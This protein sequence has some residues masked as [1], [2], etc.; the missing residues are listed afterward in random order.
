MWYFCHAFKRGVDR[1]Y[2]Y[3][4]PR[5][6]FICNAPWVRAGDVLFG[7]G[8]KNTF[9]PTTPRTP[10]STQCF[11]K[12]CIIELNYKSYPLAWLSLTRDWI[13]FIW[14]LAHVQ[15]ASID[16]TA[17]KLGMASVYA[18]ERKLCDC[19][20]KWHCAIYCRF[21]LLLCPWHS[22]VFLLDYFVSS[23]SSL[24]GSFL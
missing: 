1:S 3:W 16:L 15:M 6:Y 2:T 24:T 8:H 9:R 4:T 5:D 7:Q 10:A 12:V 22:D 13:H 20:I 18:T 11:T 23:H 14:V 17:V 21:L 19:G